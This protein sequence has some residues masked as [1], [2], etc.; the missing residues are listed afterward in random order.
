MSNE[1]DG[2]HFLL[3]FRKAAEGD[4]LRCE[5]LFLLIFVFTSFNKIHHRTFD[6]SNLSYSQLDGVLMQLPWQFPH[7]AFDKRAS[8]WCR[9]A[10]T[11]FPPVNIEWLTHECCVVNLCTRGNNYAID[12]RDRS[13][14]VAAMKCIIVLHF[15]CNRPESAGGECGFDEML[16]EEKC[17]ILL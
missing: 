9:K 1:R 6:S 5:K 11:F 2:Y 12:I 4:V 8:W 7:F 15:A 16:S 13:A 3:V 17:W 10:F 14:L